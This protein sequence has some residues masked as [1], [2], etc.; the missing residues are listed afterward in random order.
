M[1]TAATRRHAPC[2]LAFR[3]LSTAL[4][5]SALLLPSLA[6]A[7][8]GTGRATGDVT[9]NV[10]F[11]T[12]INWASPNRVETSDDL[13]A[14]TSLASGETSKYLLTSDFNYVLP[15]DAVI[16]GVEVRVE[17]S[18]DPGASIFDA[19]VR[20]YVAGSPA[21][22]DHAAAGEWSATD[23]VVVYGGPGDT[24]G[25]SL[26]AAE[27]T[28]ADFGA[29][30]S[31]MRTSGAGTLFA[32]IDYVDVIVYYSSASTP[33]ALPITLSSFSATP[34]GTGVKVAWS[35][36]SESQSRSFTIER[37]A[38]GTHFTQA[39][40]VDAQQTASSYSFYDEAAFTGTSFYRLRMTDVNG[41][42]TLSSTATVQVA[43]D[44]EWSF[45]AWPNPAVTELSVTVK[46]VSNDVN[47]Q[48]IDLKGSLVMQRSLTAADAFTTALDVSQLG[49]GLYV[50]RTVNGS[51]TQSAKVLLQ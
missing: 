36:A 29:V 25:L 21:G 24:W 40:T 44:D 13:H 11:G 50:L 45:S 26:T 28:A 2:L 46:G 27:V 4:L 43:G 35:T 10:P 6:P 14:R 19:S 22:T 15:G 12:S 20:L 41:S 37:S 16:T 39:G 33:C 42:S 23:A 1:K 51:H 5:L 47:L 8:C 30:I 18:Q 49:R 38:D 3:L 31:S 17:R 7:Q 48:L 34:A 32:R 9:G